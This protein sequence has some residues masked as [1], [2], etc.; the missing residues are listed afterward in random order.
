MV[1]IVN[2]GG[3]RHLVNPIAPRKAKI[4]CNFGLSECN[5][6]DIASILGRC[7]TNACLLRL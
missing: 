1:N 3:K 7:C 2:H 5:W 4:I 6:V